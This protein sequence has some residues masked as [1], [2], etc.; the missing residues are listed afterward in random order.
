M[1]AIILEGISKRYSKN[2]KALGYFFNNKNNTIKTEDNQALN[3]INLHVKPGEFFGL[4]GPNGAGKTTLISILSGLTYPT[5]GNAKIYGFDIIKEYKKTRRLLG[6]V[7]QELIY[8]PFFTVRETLKLQSGYF[9]LRKNDD[10]ID[11]I[12]FNLSLAEKSEHN[13]RSLSGG[14]KRRVLIAQALVHKPPII[15]LDEP[16]AG[17]D[18]ELRHSMWNFISKLNKKGHTILLTTHYLE[19]AENLC[20]RIAVL[21]SGRLVALDYTKDLLS[22]IGCQNLEEAFVKITNKKDF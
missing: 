21:K 5:T 20:E 15:I 12:L 22:K 13:M 1:C 6:I 16:T 10:W 18:I 8:D 4:I 7:P 2:K 3:N 9:G 11:E 17:V 19:E 14:M